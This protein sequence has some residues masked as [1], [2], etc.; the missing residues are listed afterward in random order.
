[1]LRSR[2][3]DWLVVTAVAVELAVV[4]V[5]AAVVAVVEVLVVVSLA[6]ASLAAVVVVAVVALFA[7][8]VAVG[9]AVAAF[10]DLAAWWVVDPALDALGVLRGAHAPEA[11]DD[12]PHAREQDQRDCRDSTAQKPR[13]TLAGSEHAGEFAGAVGALWWLGRLHACS[14]RRD[15][16]LALRAGWE[17]AEPVARRVVLWLAQL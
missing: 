5:D 17:S 6:A 7:A 8:A 15:P 10:D 11:D 9:C 2:S 13:A 3:Y 14:L 12:A 16:R 4:A 1:V